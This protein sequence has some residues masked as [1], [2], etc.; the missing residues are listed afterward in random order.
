MN[1]ADF[2]ENEER[3]SYIVCRDRKDT[4]ST[5]LSTWAA[6]NDV[7]YGWFTFKYPKEEC[8][9]ADVVSRI[10]NQITEIEQVIYSKDDEV[11]LT[12][13]QYID[14]DSFVDYFVIF[15]IFF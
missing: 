15:Q 4:T 1:I 10:E 3:L 14:V 5:T 7:C 9:T 2:D 12:Y 8:L 11:F 6:E 13:P